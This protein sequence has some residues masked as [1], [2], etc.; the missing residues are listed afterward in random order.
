MKPL[1]RKE[2]K[3]KVKTL[4][5]EVFEI[6]GVLFSSMRQRPFRDYYD[7]FIYL[8]KKLEQKGFISNDT[9]EQLSLKIFFE[10]VLPSLKHFFVITKKT[11]KPMTRH[12]DFWKCLSLFL[13]NKQLHSS[14]FIENKC[15]IM[16]LESSRYRKTDIR[17]YADFL[18][19]HY[20]KIVFNK[21]YDLLLVNGMPFIDT[22]LNS[23]S[24]KDYLISK[25]DKID[26]HD[27]LFITLCSDFGYDWDAIKARIAMLQ[28]NNEQAFFVENQMLIPALFGK[29]LSASKFGVL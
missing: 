24:V 5:D 18:E 29:T 26:V 21:V 11:K 4:L 14:E 8:Y 19:N 13:E 17:I 25:L 3:H 15:L 22:Y 16:D 12:T 9:F 7:Y 6:L 2:F 27:E 10:D 28:R 23:Y 1:S 20:P